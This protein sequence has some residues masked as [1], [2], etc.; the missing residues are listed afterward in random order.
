MKT[1]HVAVLAISLVT[2]RL[3]EAE[4]AP[5]QMLRIVTQAEGPQ[6]D[7]NSFAAK[8]KTVYRLGKKYARIEEEPDPPNKIHALIVSSAPHNWMVNLYDRTGRHIVDPDPNGDVVIPLFPPGSFGG[9][10][11]ELGE[12]EMGCEVAFFESH[13]SPIRAL[14]SKGGDRIQQA[15]GVSDWKLVLVRRAS[16]A[17]PEMLFVFKGSEIVFTLRYL[18]FEMLAQPDMKKFA[19][20]EGIQLREEPAG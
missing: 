7:A 15:L 20:P 19:K 4:C 2:A 10:P 3:L 8:P 13:G 16:Q 17:P 5:E 11:T 6:I 14:K 1:I 12:I 18:S 9:F